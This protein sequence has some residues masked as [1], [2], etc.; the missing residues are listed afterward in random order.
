MIRTLDVE[1]FT[2]FPDREIFHFVKGINVVVG[3][4]DSGKS[5]L[6]KLAYAAAKWSAGGGNKELPKLWAEENRLRLALMRVFGA[7]DL[8]GLTALNRGNARAHVHVSM[9]GEGVPSGAGE[10]LFS[11]EANHEE[12]GLH[13]EEMPARFVRENVVFLSAREILSIYPCYMQVGKRY[14]ELLDGTSWDLCRHLEEVPEEALSDVHMQRVLERIEKILSGSLLRMDGRFYLKRPGQEPME[15]SLVAEG[16]KRLGTLGMLI[17]SGVVHKGSILFW[18]EPEMNLNAGYLPRIVKL[19]LELAKGGVQVILSTHSLF[20][21]RELVMQLTEERNAQVKRHFFGLQ[22]PS[23]NRCGVR[24]KQGDTLDEVGP[25]AA[26]EAEVEQADR[27]L[28]M[29]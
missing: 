6:M 16:F 23:E 13:I 1:G 26:R 18:D 10:L 8:S 25:L 3:G 27:Y 19:L 2:L 9:E 4:N 7:R 24:M 28:K 20:L 21:L 29:S 5:H 22:V 11:F 14:P 12:E 15:M 17:K